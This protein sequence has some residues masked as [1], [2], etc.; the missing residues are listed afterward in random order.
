MEPGEYLQ[1]RYYQHWLHGLE[2]LLL[3]SGLIALDELPYT[4]SK[5]AAAAPKEGE[6]SN[7]TPLPATAIPAEKIAAILSRGGP[8]DY[9][10]QHPAKFSIDEEVRVLQNHPKGHTRAPR[11]IRGQHGLITQYRGSYLLP[12]DH[13]LP[14]PCKTPAHLYSV[15]FSAQDLWGVQIAEVNS[16][17]YV[18][19]F[20][21]YLDTIAC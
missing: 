16:A 6:T 20:E 10:A 18:D 9:P 14:H 4:N 19:V 5:P 12:D 13:S 2:Q 7:K 15:R 1:S 11:F 21:P 8:A 17:V 3:E